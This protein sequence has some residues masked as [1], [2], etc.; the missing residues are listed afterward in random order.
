MVGDAIDG[1]LLQH[2][3]LVERRAAPAGLQGVLGHVGEGRRRG[4]IAPEGGGEGFGGKR[5]DRRLELHDRFEREG[6]VG[7]VFSEEPVSA[8]IPRGERF[9]PQGLGDDPGPVILLAREREAVQ[10]EIQENAQDE[11]VEVPGVPRHGGVDERKQFREAHFHAGHVRAGNLV[12]ARFH[13]EIVIVAVPGY[14]LADR[15]AFGQVARVHE[16][17][18]RVDRERGLPDRQECE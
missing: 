10:V 9:D 18:E 11:E 15:P 1:V 3:R 2:V 16:I 4:V 8:E 7:V 12:A 14:F 5:V 6:I 17:L 13:D